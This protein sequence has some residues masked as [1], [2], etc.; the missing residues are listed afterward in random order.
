MDTWKIL[1]TVEEDSKAKLCNCIYVNITRSYL[2]YELRY[3]LGKRRF[4]SENIVS[5][6]S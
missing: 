5:S 2:K 4:K 1:P 3:F 6:K